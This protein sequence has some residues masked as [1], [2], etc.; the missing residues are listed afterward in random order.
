MLSRHPDGLQAS[1]WR[2]GPFDQ[3]LPE[4]TPV[5]CVDLALPVRRREDGG[6]IPTRLS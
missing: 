5:G 4:T 3:G 2:R 1:V 6:A